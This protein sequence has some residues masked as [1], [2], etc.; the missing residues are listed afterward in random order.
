MIF[1]LPTNTCFWVAT[2]IND[3]VWYKQIYTIKWRIE[4]KPFAIMCDSINYIKENTKLNT[5][6]IDFIENYSTP[7]T[8][9]LD[10]KKIKDKKLLTQ[11]DLLPN[12]NKYLKIAFRVAHNYMHRKLIDN[13]WLLFLT[14][15][16]KSW[17]SEIF[18]SKIVREEFQ[19]EIQKLEIKVLAH[20]WFSI[21]NNQKSS[22]IF[23]FIWESIELKYL[24]K[25]IIDKL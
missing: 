7:Y 18:D 5:T 11:I 21:S 14:S 1:I 19:N 9:L 15:A 13:Y 8:I 4:D 16:N 6:Q 25:N 24:R 17:K 20:P 2:P 12:A 10:R 23:E 3:I 22:D